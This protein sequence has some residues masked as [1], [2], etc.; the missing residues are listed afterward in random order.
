MKSLSSWISLTSSLVCKRTATHVDLGLMG[1][2]GLW[3]SARSWRMW[4]GIAM[5]RVEWRITKHDD[6]NGGVYE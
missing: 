1:S 6:Y 2:L 4:Y 5:I 3:S